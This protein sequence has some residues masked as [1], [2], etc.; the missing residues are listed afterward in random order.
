MEKTLKIRTKDRKYI[1]ASLWSPHKN[2]TNKPVVVV[3]H[4]L[5]GN[6]F[7]SKSIHL[8]RMLYKI[9]IASLRVSLYSWEPGARS[10]SQSSLITHANDLNRV[11][12]YLRSLK[13][14]TLIGVGHSLGFPCLLAS[15]LN[16]LSGIVSW[17]GADE[18]IFKSSIAVKKVP[19]TKV[20]YLPW[21]NEILVGEATINRKRPGD[22]LSY[23]QR[24]ALMHGQLLVI[25][26]GNALARAAVVREGKRLS[27]CEL[28]V[29]EGADHNFTQVGLEERLIAHTVR[30]CR[31]AIKQKVQW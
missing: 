10:F 24:R 30:F 21:G 19:N 27:D 26:A 31:K 18:S 2:I 25:A 20:R 14:S 4:G 28:L 16:Y 6:R 11:Y 3:V 9:G 15:K 8:A 5:T 23:Q 1:Y 22:F 12:E 13:V 7:E 17:D 29:I